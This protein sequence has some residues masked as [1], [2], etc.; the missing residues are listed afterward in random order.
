M[1]QKNI[2]LMVVAV[3]CGLVAAFLTSQMSAKQVDQVD[4]VVAAKDLAVGTTLTRDEL[5]DLVKIVK[6]PKDGLPVTV[7][8]NPEDLVEKRLSRPLRADEPITTQDLGKGPVVT[9]PEGYHMMSLQVNAAQAAAGFVG[10]GSRVNVNATLKLGT[11]LEAF[12]L[13][14]NMLVVAVDTNIAYAKDSNGTFPS[15]NTVSFAVK[16]KEALL[17]SLAKS[18][19]CTIELLLRN[20][21]KTLDSDKK[22]NIDEVIKLLSDDKEKSNIAGAVGGDTSE[23]KPEPTE[24]KVGEKTPEKVV[25]KVVEKPVT[26]VAPAPSVAMVKVLVAKQDIAP[27]TEIT[28]DLIAEAFE[29]KALPKEFAGSALGDLSEALGQALKTGV[30]K[31]QWVTPGMVGIQTPKTP[32]QEFFQPSKPPVEGPKA[33]VEPQ[34]V[35]PVVKKKTLD[36]AVHTAGGSMIHRYE[37]TAPGKWKKIAELTPEQAAKGDQ[38]APAPQDE[39]KAEPDNKFRD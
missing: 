6:R 18:R 25:E 29:E 19:G 3:G 5:K 2:V 1:K 23:K 36:V 39:K 31:G 32:P 8:L 22:Y 30:S 35:A 38:A 14:V 12:P 4:V 13:L 15:M 26:P 37:E 33:P 28:K 24:P 21:N 11:K 17:L 10:P 34:P 20:Q 16:E 7:V 9:L 27:N